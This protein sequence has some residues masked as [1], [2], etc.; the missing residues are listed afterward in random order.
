MVYLW[1]AEFGNF[2]QGFHQRE[3]KVQTVQVK[4]EGLEGLPLRPVV[5]KVWQLAQSLLLLVQVETFDGLH[6]APR[7]RCGNEPPKS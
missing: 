5:G 6:G 2:S 3:V 7:L 1:E 4:L